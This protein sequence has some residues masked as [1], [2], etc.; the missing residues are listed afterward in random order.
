ME[1]RNRFQK[2]IEEFSSEEFIS[3]KARAEK[4]CAQS[5]CDLGVCYDFGRGVL[6][7]TVEAV[8]WFR[9]AAEQGHLDAQFNLGCA[10]EQGIGVPKDEVEAYA[11]YNLVGAQAPDVREDITNLEQRLSRGEIAAGQ[12]RTKELQEEIEASK[13][14]D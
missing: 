8:K 7:N 13:A 12:R 11:Y 4:G 10:Y 1:V 2:W 6:Q 9:K 3:L 14:I 5:Q